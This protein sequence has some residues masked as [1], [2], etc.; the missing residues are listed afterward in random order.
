MIANNFF[1]VLLIEVCGLN[2]KV[3]GAA[4]SLRGRAG[5]GLPYIRD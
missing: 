2:G 4:C 5:S 1:D 3:P